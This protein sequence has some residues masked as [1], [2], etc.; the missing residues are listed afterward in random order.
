MPNPKLYALFVGI[1]K[2]AGTVKGLNGCVNDVSNLQQYVNE[3]LTDSF[4][5][6]IKTLTNEQAT[7]ETIISV[8]QA[9]LG[10]AKEGDFVWFHFSGHGS[11]EL[12]AMEFIPYSEDDK[13]QTL[14]CYDSRT[15]NKQDL[16]DKELGALIYEVAK[17]N[18]KMVVTLDACHSGGGTR[19][20]ERNEDDYEGRFEDMRETRRNYDTYLNGY[21][22]SKQLVEVPES[23]YM[24]FSACGAKEQALEDRRRR[25]GLFTA[26]LIDTLSL[27][28]STSIAY[29]D[30]ANI[31]YYQIK[32][33]TG[34]QN[35]QASAMLNFDGTQLFMVNQPSK[36][37]SGSGYFLFNL[38]G[39][40]NV[41]IGVVHGLNPEKK[42]LK[43]HIFEAGS[44]DSPPVADGNV[45]TIGVSSSKVEVEAN[46][47]AANKHYEIKFL[48][49]GIDPL[50][51]YVKDAQL[52]QMLSA[53]LSE[54]D[55]AFIEFNDKLTTLDWEVTNENGAYQI[56]NKKTQR[57]FMQNAVI[58]NTLSN[59]LKMERKMRL[60]RLHNPSSSLMEREFSLKLY[61]EADTDSPKLYEASN[62]EHI[63]KTPVGGKTRI[64]LSAENKSGE[65][66]FFMILYIANDFSITVI[67]N[68][69]FSKAGGEKFVINKAGLHISDPSLKETNEEFLLFVCNERLDESMFKQSKLIDDSKMEGGHRDLTFEEDMGS[70]WLVKRVKVKLTTI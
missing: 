5:V 28:K 61:T 52:R 8:F 55:K 67:K 10:Q 14:V 23:N 50:R 64:R 54:G 11:E 2:Y 65:N 9:H 58:E 42:P 51:V 46:K 12:T 31:L 59:L 63:I 66:L 29:N 3:E 7:R 25:C 49:M 45:I 38:N 43:V 1:D 17:N 26:S 34:R 19:G 39:E 53:N 15:P 68:E 56:K 69:L 41:N 33:K 18:P 70:T 21:F 13:N 27:Y 16:A 47:L 36:R 60:N 35:P 40:W 24:V 37:D 62:E 4:E 48:N 30:L 44:K 32:E 6:N 20:E 22:S 57:V